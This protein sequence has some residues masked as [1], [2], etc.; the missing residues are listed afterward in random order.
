MAENYLYFPNLSKEIP[1][2]PSDSIVSR[3]VRDDAQVKV[4][5][6]GFA[7]GQALSE[8]TA[9]MPAIIHILDGK[10][11]LLLG[12]D[13]QE[14]QSDSWVYMPA[15]LAHSVIAETPV[16]MALYMLKGGKV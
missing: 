9:S 1:A 6:F 8:H 7:P 13:P 11:R 14:A 4:V 2:V 10:A 5:L 3:T 16:T 15:N 12:G